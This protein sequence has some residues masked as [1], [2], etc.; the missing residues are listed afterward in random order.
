MR[1]IIELSLDQ[2]SKLVRPVQPASHICQE[3][4]SQPGQQEHQLSWSTP[5]SSRQ[6]DIITKEVTI[7]I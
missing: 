7:I 5:V 6:N 1:L 3:P 2:F 4:N